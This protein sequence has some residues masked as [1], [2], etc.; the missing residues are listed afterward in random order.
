MPFRS[1]IKISPR[2]GLRLMPSTGSDY[3]KKNDTSLNPKEYPTGRNI[4][5]IIR[6]TVAPPWVNECSSH[7]RRFVRIFQ[8]CLAWGMLQ[9]YHQESRNMA[10]RNKSPHIGESDVLTWML[11]TQCW[12]HCCLVT[13]TS[14]CEMFFLM[15]L[16]QSHHPYSQTMVCGFV[17]SEI[18]SQEIAPGWSILKTWKH[19]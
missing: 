1:L 18:Y 5:N 10:K 12:E 6:G 15:S 2:Q 13:P 8:E 7:G 14:M 19:C 9:C 11:P 17:K 3:R 16:H 4:V